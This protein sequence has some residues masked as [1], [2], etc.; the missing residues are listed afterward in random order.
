MISRSIIILCSIY[1]VLSVVSYGQWAQTGG[2]E[3]GHIDDIIRVESALFVSAGNGGVY[4]SVDNGISWASCNSGIPIN[5]TIF[6]LQSNGGNL[7]ISVYGNGLFYSDDLGVTWEAINTGIET[8]TF[9]NFIV[10]GTTIYAG[11]ANGGVFYSSDKGTTWTDKSVGIENEQMQAF[12]IFESKI[13]AGGT[14]LYA[15]SNNGD[16]WET[17][18]IPNLSVNGV[19]SLTATTTKLFASGGG[20]FSSEDGSAWTKSNNVDTYNLNSSV[21]SVYFVTDQGFNYSLNNGTSWSFVSYLDGGRDV[22]FTPD[23]ILIAS[24]N[25]IHIS[26][27][28]GLTWKSSSKGVSAV[29]INSMIENSSYLFTSTDINK[30]Y[31]SADSG[32]TWE[33]LAQDVE[34]Y[35]T[36]D[37]V[38]IGDSVFVGTY[39]GLYVS[40]NNGDSWNQVFY[41]GPN[42]SVQRLNFDNGVLVAAVNGDGVYISMD[43]AKTW[44]L[45]ATNGMNIDTGY[46]SVEMVGDTIIISTSNGEIFVSK[47]VGNS[48]DELLI[49]S[50]YTFTHKVKLYNNTLYAATAQGGLYSSEDLGLSWSLLNDFG[51]AVYDIEIENDKIYVG[52]GLGVYI[53]STGRDVWYDVGHG[54]EDKTTTELLISNNN[55][56]AGTYGYSAWFRSLGELN[57]PPI[58]LGS[59]NP[60]ITEEETNFS[61]LIGD[62]EVDDPDNQFPEDFTLTILPGDN[63]RISDNQIVP[64]VDFNGVLSVHITI[65][66][67][68]EDSPEFDLPIEITPINDAPTIMG[69]VNE[70]VTEEATPISIELNNLVIVDPDN[71]FPEDFTIVLSSGDNYSISENLITPNS[72][73]IGKLIV[74]VLVNDGIDDSPLF[75]IEIEVMKI[76][77]NNT[78]KYSTTSI[79]V[80]PNPSKSKMTVLFSNEIIGIVQIKLLGIDG[81]ELHYN[82]VRKNAETFTDIIDV[83]SFERG[84]YVLKIEIENNANMIQRVFIY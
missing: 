3:G 33:Q 73:F 53:S 82:K 72:G 43:S 66:D 24:D 75:N 19:N 23:Q 59:T 62:L 63:Y 11:N 22:L 52:T 34:M 21:D 40:D 35:D 56:Y 7:Y 55:L 17:I 60:L 80:F 36:Y 45:T 27:D 10:E 31:R 68:L 64:E 42:K 2:P 32:D 30:I 41:P 58:V 76:T 84:L 65:N 51:T 57:L 39:N 78:E 46:E 77:A 6:N 48:W 29:Q 26:K 83:S 8:M 16:S 54:L 13:Y 71:Q 69:F 44:N 28:I 81:R 14:Q 79:K 12:E 37:M 38:T 74:P 5:S 61:I 25:G 9:Y 15:S 4:K 49:L 1:F 20:V 67:G 50:E 47:D 70:F 18:T